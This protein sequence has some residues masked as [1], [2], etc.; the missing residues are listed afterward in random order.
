[1]RVLRAALHFIGAAGLALALLGGTPIPAFAGSS[2]GT[3]LA[4]STARSAAD[5]ANLAIT[6]SVSP[7][8]LIAGAPAVYTVTVRNTGNAAAANVTTTL[9]FTPANALTIGS[10]LPAGCAPAAQTVTCTEATIPAAGTV[11]YQIPVTVLPGVADGTNI[12]LRAIATADGVPAAGT[13]L[14]TQAFTRVDV[15]I[16][17]TGPATVSPGG[18]MT[19]TIT[20][21]N[22]GPSDAATVTWYDPLDGNLTTITSHPCGPTGLTITCSLGTLAPGET[23]TFLITLTVN[24]SVPAGAVIPDCAV[25]V[26]G[27]PDT[28]PDNNQSCINTTVGT[29]QPPVSDIEIVKTAPATVE[30]G[31]TIGYSVTVTNH[32]PAPATNV[33]VS[34][35]ITVPVDSV[36]SLPS[37]CTLQGITVTC[38]A[39]PWR[40]A[41][42]GRSP[43]RSRSARPSWRAPASWTAPP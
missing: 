40:S 7:T 32:G 20:V 16:V 34:D 43:S 26:T 25:V 38:Q 4:S 35:P 36:P 27:S 8:P 29:G 19:Y 1:M 3:G 30:E 12:A 17:K 18:A 37:D 42:P 23:R 21:T 15:E 9:P 10:P 2:T 13:D 33:I 6:A 41:R 14:I 22:H 24:P 31:G 39:G 11:T 28:N 5:P